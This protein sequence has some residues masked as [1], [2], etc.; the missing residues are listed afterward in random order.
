MNTQII[1]DYKNTINAKNA[2]MQPLHYEKLILQK[3]ENTL[4]YYEQY[5]KV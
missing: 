5:D 3:P 4:R 1:K 2:K